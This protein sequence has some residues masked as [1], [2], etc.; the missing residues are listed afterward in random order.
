MIRLACVCCLL[1][2]PALG[3]PIA[4]VI[5]APTEQMTQRL[6]RQFGET[7]TAMGIRGPDQIMEIWTRE[8]GQSWTMVITYAEGNSCIVAMGETWMT[9]VPETADPA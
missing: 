4:E 1:A 7:R 5:C 6:T 2:A 9:L 3:N 8:D